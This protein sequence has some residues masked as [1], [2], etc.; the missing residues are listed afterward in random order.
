MIEL[1]S[2]I[3]PECGGLLRLNVS[4]T[5]GTCKS[6]GTTVLIAGV[7]GLRQELAAWI[8]A[9]HQLE[10]GDTDKAAQ[11]FQKVIDLNPEFGEAYF[12]LFECEVA[13]AEYYR[14]LNSFM[15]RCI[16]EYIDSLYNAINKHGKR[17]I[18]YAP[19][20]ETQ[21]KYQTRVD[22][23]VRTLQNVQNAPTKKKGFLSRFLG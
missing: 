16:P 7:P 10:D 14:K 6:C 21:S 3:C 23:I 1:K 17:A 11:Y 15:A 8:T 4:Q 18:Q 19:D 2:A 5:S 22:E 9:N 20:T 13:A 12:A